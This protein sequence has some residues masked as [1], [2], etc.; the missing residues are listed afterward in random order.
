M[1]AQTKAKWVEALRS[2]KYKQG[3]GQLRL[4]DTYCCL[5]VLCDIMGTGWTTVGFP[6]ADLNSLYVT[7][8]DGDDTLPSDGF[9]GLGIHAME[10]LAAMNDGI[11][12]YHK[13]SFSEIATY[14]EEAF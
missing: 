10:N 7:A 9:C 12:D 2:G 8:S 14:I 4:G 6:Q 3:R 5:G 13:H 1:D 11:Q